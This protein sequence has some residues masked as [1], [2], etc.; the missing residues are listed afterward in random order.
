MAGGSP[1]RSGGSEAMKAEE[2]FRETG[3]IRYAALV[4]G[5]PYYVGHE[6]PFL[7]RGLGRQPHGQ[8]AGAAVIAGHHRPRFHGVRDQ[9]RLLQPK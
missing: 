1:P 3:D 4:L 2:W 5:K 8:V 6:A 7:V 9:A